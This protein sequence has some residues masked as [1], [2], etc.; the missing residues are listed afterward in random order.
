MTESSLLP[1]FSP[2]WYLRNG[3]CQTVLG[4]IRKAT[5]L[6]PLT[7]K[8]LDTPDDDFLDLDWHD[9][10]PSRPLLFICHGLESCALSPDVQNLMACADS[11]GVSSVAMNFRG[12]SGEPNRLAPSYNAGDTRDLHFA[13]EHIQQNSPGRMVWLSGY[14]L[15]G[16]VIAKWA[17]EQGENATSWAQAVAVVCVPY[18]LKACQE[19]MDRPWNRLVRA[20]FFRTMI[21]RAKAKAERFPGS[22]DWERAQHAT[23]FAEFD[24]AV[25][26]QLFGFRDYIHYYQESSSLP[27]LQHI[28]IPTLLL[29]AM[30]DPIIPAAV[31]PSEEQVAPCVERLFTRHGGHCGYVGDPTHPDWMVRQV[32]KWL[33]HATEY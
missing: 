26:A 30:D 1:P 6:L 4:A 3:Y 13:L 27:W 21:P 22:F 12:C 5:R 23:T 29:S 33:L 7:R 18:D 11:C 17:G 25:T 10:N 9:P 16:N 8:R 15:G 28:H 20:R 14:S 24:D 19:Q 31:N 32:V 2:P